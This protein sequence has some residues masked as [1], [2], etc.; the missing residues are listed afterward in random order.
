MQNVTMVLTCKNIDDIRTSLDK[1]AGKHSKY[2]LPKL[3]I[4]IMVC[5]T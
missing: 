1:S 4:I 2:I 5:R 3:L